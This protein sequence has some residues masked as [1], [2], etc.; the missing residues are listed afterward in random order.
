[1]AGA[2]IDIHMGDPQLF[3]SLADIAN[4]LLVPVHGVTVPAQ[5]HLT[6]ALLPLALFQ[7]EENFAD[8]VEN[9]GILMAY[10]DGEVK[11]VGDD[12][13]HARMDHNLAGGVDQILIAQLVNFLVEVAQGLGGS[14]EGV[15]A[16]LHGEGAGVSRK[17]IELHTIEHLAQHAGDYANVLAGIL[18][19]GTLLDVG[20]KEGHVFLGAHT[21]GLVALIGE[22][23][24]TLAKGNIR[25]Q[26]RLRGHHLAV[27]KV[28]PE[29]FGHVIVCHGAGAHHAGRE[30]RPLLV[31]ENHGSQ[32]VAMGDVFPHHGFQHFHGAHHAQ[33]TVI[34]AAVFHAVAVRSHYDALQAG[35]GAGERG[36]HVSQIIHLNCGTNSFHPTQPF[37]T[38]HLVLF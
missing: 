7:A 36:I 25:R 18:Q 38:S 23:S 9:L 21:V 33:N 14:V 15:M 22:G 17:A 37:C 8:L 4:Q 19:D 16:L 6:F 2:R 3:H 28:I 32:G 24:Q 29:T 35:L 27:L 12:R 26:D 20:L 10:I 13:I 11:E 5:N 30:L 1:M 34:V 31:R